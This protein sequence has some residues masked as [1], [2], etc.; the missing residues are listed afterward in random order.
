[1]SVGENLRRIRKARGLGQ[2]ALA[3]LAGT[4]Q[5]TISEIETG[6]RDPHQS[7]LQALADALGVPLA[8]FFEEEPAPQGPPPA[9]KTPLTRASDRAFDRQ[10]H[11]ADTEHKVRAL[12]NALDS[13]IE[14]LVR[15]RA[16][17]ERFSGDQAELE[18]AQR[19]L[20]T[21]QPRWRAA[22]ELWADFVVERDP[23]RA[24]RAERAGEVG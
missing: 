20:R 14:A 3:D 11:R 19:L 4:S 12:R 8:A 6:Q 1:M 22:A 13:E 18:E 9:P 24:S 23:E 7:T 17:L 15:W 21:A 5:A 10:L 2:I 16:A